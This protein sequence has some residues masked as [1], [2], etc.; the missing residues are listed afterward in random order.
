M[1]AGFLVPVLVVVL[2]ALNCRSREREKSETGPVRKGRAMPELSGKRVLMVVARDKFRDEELLKPR[3]ILEQAGAAV[4]IASS[5]LEEATGMLGARVKPDVLLTDVSADDYDALVFVGGSGASEYFDNPTA[6]ALA[7]A[8]AQQGKV[9]A[10]MCIAASTL[11]NAGVL[12]GRRATC[13]SSEA[14]NL[15]AKGAQ[16][17]AA[18][19]ERD[20]LIITG[21]G[22]EAAGQ[23]G[24]ALVEALAGN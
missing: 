15:K 9:L 19:V 14:G 1:R 10:A 6:H 5:S 7:Q 13:W 17:T 24:E 21:E 4:T 12:Q 11:A 8:A 18:P 23:F 2:L 20:G 16:Y 22:P 3:A